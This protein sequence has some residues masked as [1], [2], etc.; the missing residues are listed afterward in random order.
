MKLKILPGTFDYYAFDT[1]VPP[2]LLGSP[3]PAFVCQVPGDYSFMV[4]A[5]TRVAGFTEVEPNWYGFSIEGQLLFTEVGI[6]ASITSALG[7]AG[8]SVLVMSGYRTDYF[9]VKDITGA[10]S[11][12][13]DAG[14]Q[15]LT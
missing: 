7:D 3:E 9:F 8:I 2:E 10:R 15:F 1:P 12:L 4:T 6:A 5:G 14:H 13:I 11:C